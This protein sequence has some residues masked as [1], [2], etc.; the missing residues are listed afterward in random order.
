MRLNTKGR[1]PDTSMQTKMSI[2]VG[3]A[4]KDLVAYLAY[5]FRIRLEEDQFRTAR[6]QKFGGLQRS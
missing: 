6:G 3:L 5:I 2:T 4:R 1:S